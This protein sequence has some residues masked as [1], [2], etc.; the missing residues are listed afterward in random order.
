M[1][2]GNALLPLNSLGCSY[3]LVA[4][5]YKPFRGVFAIE[6][7]AEHAH[8]RFRC[9]AFGAVPILYGRFRATT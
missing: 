3:F 7:C 8:K 6:H 4:V 9:L 1:V 2:K 5:Y